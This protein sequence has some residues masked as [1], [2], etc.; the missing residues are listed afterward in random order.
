[1]VI[2][3]NPSMNHHWNNLVH[4]NFKQS[5]KVHRKITLMPMFF[6]DF[7]GPVH[8]D[9]F[10]TVRLLTKIYIYNCWHSIVYSCYSR[11][12]VSRKSLWKW[13]CPIS[14]AIFSPTQ[15][16][17]RETVLLLMCDTILFPNLLIIFWKANRYMSH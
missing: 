8:H 10:R 11:C 4:H 6:C 15:F 2:T 7:K 5:H 17:T 12:L 16:C 13:I 9:M 14:A 1:M 3:L